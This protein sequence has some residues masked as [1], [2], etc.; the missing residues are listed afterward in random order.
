[1]SR[2]QLFAIGIDELRDM[3]GAGPELAA[4][5][6]TVA[7]A[8]YPASPGPKPR[9]GLLGRVGPLLRHPIDGPQV[10][11]GPS[12]VD[13]ENLLSGRYVAPQRLPQAWQII[14]AWLSALG[15]GHLDVPWSSTELSQLDFEL[16]RCGLPVDYS[17]HR[18]FQEDLQLPVGHLPGGRAGYSRHRHVL[19][20][21]E[22]LTTIIDDVEPPWDELA[23]TLLAWLNHFPDWARSAEEA[24]RPLPDVVGLQWP[25]E[26]SQSQAT[27]GAA[28]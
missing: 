10:P 9:T 23:G 21:R 19:A 15:W 1:M 5:L 14:A 7:T 2:L 28:S 18:L 22:A 6:R 13:A 27:A 12:P 26:P 11:E 20:T 24:D 8:C 25:D 4:R 17:V 3:F 16:A